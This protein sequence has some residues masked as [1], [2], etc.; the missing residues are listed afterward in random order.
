[1]ANQA[2]KLKESGQ[3]SMFNLFGESVPTPLGTIDLSETDTVLPQEKL[4]WEKEL[5][6]IYLSDNPI[7]KAVYEMNSEAIVFR[8]QLT[9]D[10]ERK[11]VILVGQV[12]SANKRL[13]KG[14]RPFL[15]ASL[16]LMDGN[17]EIA[18]WSKELVNKESLWN[19]GTFLSITGKVRLRNDQISINCEN[20]SEF[21]LP[22]LENTTDMNI[23]SSSKK[24]LAIDNTNYSED[25]Q[26]YPAESLRT[27]KAFTDLLPE[28]N[29]PT[30]RSK[31]QCLVLKVNETD[32]PIKDG[33][34]LKDIIT[35]LL[36][37]K[38]TDSVKLII[39][40]NGNS[41]EMNLPI[42]NVDC[43]QDLINSLEQ[44]MGYTGA[45]IEELPALEIR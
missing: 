39:G 31:K 37:Y 8:E 2:I 24:F 26:D 32:D 27:P 20:A 17:V 45:T 40:T 1:M 6:G 9:N 44:I 3:A 19:E 38:G 5:L 15:I 28:Q 12:I 33:I 18:V 36:D 23:K 29:L 7:S 43:T 25:T 30:A 10:M 34:F 22:S 21:D 14:Q 42:I 4:Q 13:T 16:G 11:K 35:F 41:I